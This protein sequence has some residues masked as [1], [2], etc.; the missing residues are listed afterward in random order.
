MTFVCFV[1]AFVL[2]EPTATL[3]HRFVMHHGRGWTWHASHH[4]SRGRARSFES[5]DRF[6]VLF[7]VLTVALMTAGASVDAWGALLPVGW[8]VTLYGAVYLVVHD[9]Y[10]HARFGVLPGHSLR[11][12]EWVRAAHAVHHTTGRAPYGFVLPIEVGRLESTFK[13]R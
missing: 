8:G 9:G 11:Y 2:M 3:L 1:T 4:R 5:N 7:A 6:P 13:P 10:V 12:F